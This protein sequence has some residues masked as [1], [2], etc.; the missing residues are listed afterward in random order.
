MAQFFALAQG[1]VEKGKTVT[2]TASY[3]SDSFHGKKTFNGEKLSQKKM[4]CASNR[5]KIGTWLRVTNIKNGKSII[6]Q[7]NDRM[8]AKSKRIVDLTRKGAE[9]IGMLGLGI[10][11][12]K[13]ENLGSMQP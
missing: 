2:G 11:K 9:K 3:Y 1:A 4:T 13:V 12:V 10:C 5:Y 7:V 6:V 8:G